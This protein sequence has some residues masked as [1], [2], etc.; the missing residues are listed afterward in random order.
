MYRNERIMKR[1]PWLRW[2]F[3][4]TILSSWRYWC[5]AF[6]LP[7]G[8]ISR[9]TFKRIDASLLQRIVISGPDVYRPYQTGL[10][11]T[12]EVYSTFVLY[13]IW[14][15]IFLRKIRAYP[16]NKNRELRE[17]LSVW[18]LV[19]LVAVVDACVSYNR[20]GF[21]AYGLELNTVVHQEPSCGMPDLL[22]ESGLL[23]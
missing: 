4:R 19:R 6:N 9:P 16:W 5:F 23:T 10:E 17:R 18:G 2:V 22:R 8:R 7:W 3:R 1:D 15:F 14:G 20:L 12:V 13:D 21:T 11:R